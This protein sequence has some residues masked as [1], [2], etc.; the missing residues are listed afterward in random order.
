[1]ILQNVVEL[2]VGVFIWGGLLGRCA[3]EQNA[4]QQKEPVTRT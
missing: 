3:G 2:Q 4:Y 1:M